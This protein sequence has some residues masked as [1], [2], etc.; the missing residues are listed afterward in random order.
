MKLPAEIR[1]AMNGVV[2]SQIATASKDGWPNV[3]VISQVYFVDDEHVAIS[4]QFFSKANRNLLENPQ[5]H[6]QLMDPA[7]MVPWLLEVQFEREEKSG[8]L[9]DEMEMQLEAIASMTGMQDVFKLQSA[10]VLKV[11]S[12][13]KASEAQNPG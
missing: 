7:D 1:S 10:Y 4:N 8:A 12:V 11:L 9:F 13:R 3:T 2:P 5:A 6:I